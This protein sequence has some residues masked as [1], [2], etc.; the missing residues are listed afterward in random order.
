MIIGIKYGNMHIGFTYPS[1]MEAFKQ[2]CIELIGDKNEDYKNFIKF[3]WGIKID[4][5]KA[6]RK[7]IE[8]MCTV[9]KDTNNIT[10]SDKSLNFLDEDEKRDY[11]NCNKNVCEFFISSSDFS[12]SFFLDIFKSELKKA[13]QDSEEYFSI[14]SMAVRKDMIDEYGWNYP[15]KIPKDIKNW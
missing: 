5:F 4:N 3:L 11:M 6:F 14:V 8:S 10:L 2:H 13:E 15:I 7:E 12:N 9:F 1:I